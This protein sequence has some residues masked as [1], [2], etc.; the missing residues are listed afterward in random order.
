MKRLTAV[1]LLVGIANA[2]FAQV[3]GTLKNHKDTH[4]PRLLARWEDLGLRQ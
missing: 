4:V 1:V 3:V 2:A